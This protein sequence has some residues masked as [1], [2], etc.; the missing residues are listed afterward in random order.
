MPQ[1]AHQQATTV[2]AVVTVHLHNELSAAA[3][4]LSVAIVCSD[5]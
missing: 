1:A 3:A 4:E 2:V 5:A